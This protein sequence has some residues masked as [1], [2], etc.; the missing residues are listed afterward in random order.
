MKPTI[1]QEHKHWLAIDKP[2]GWVVEAHG[3]TDETIESWVRD[4]LSQQYKNPYV[5]I[6][7]R[8]DRVTSGVLLVAKRKSALRRLNV[9]F[10]ER[11]VEKTY[12]AVVSQQPKKK[13]DKLVHFLEKDQLN[14]RAIIHSNQQQSSQR[15]TLS[16]RL[17]NS[18]NNYHLLKIQP[19]TGKFHQIRAQLAHIG[20]PIVGDQK[21]GGREELDNNTILL[22]AAR[23]VFYYPDM[24]GDKIELAAK[25]PGLEL[26]RQFDL[27]N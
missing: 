16:Y 17:L 9:Q 7:H 4:Y 23:L 22:H 13:Q 6:V 18:K 15:V 8:L 19:S 14:K 11:E 3:R 5:G 24:K 20:C 21:Y 25:T 1:I 26:W 10:A 12:L 27:T 2:S